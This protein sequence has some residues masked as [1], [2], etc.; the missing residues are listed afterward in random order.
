[1]SLAPRRRLPSTTFHTIDG[2]SDEIVI[3]VLARL[4]FILHG[5]LRVVCRRVCTLV[6]S[7]SFR[8]ERLETGFA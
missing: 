8:K 2:I 5:T 7:E 6:S 1:M 3:A 4:P